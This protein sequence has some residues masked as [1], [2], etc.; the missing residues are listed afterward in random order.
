M[1][2][3][4][5]YFWGN[6]RVFVTGATGLVGP[7]LIKLL[8]DKGA[9]VVALINNY[10][11]PSELFLSGNIHRVTVIEGSIDEYSVIENVLKKQDIE[12][13]FHLAST[14]NNYGKAF[15]PLRTFDTNI[16]GTYNLLEACRLFGDKSMC[17]VTTS[18][19]EV[20]RDQN[21]S[22]FSD[23]ITQIEHPYEASKKSADMIC[24]VYRT[25]YGLNVSTII[26]P[27]LYGGGDFN[28][29]RIVPGTI[30]S[31]I[32]N[33]RPIIRSNG[34]LVRSYLYVLDFVQALLMIAENS[35]SKAKG[36]MI[37]NFKEIELLSTIEIVKRII[38]RSKHYELKPVIQNTSKDEKRYLTQSYSN[39]VDEIGWSQN[40]TLDEGL[41]DTIEWY[42]NYFNL[43]PA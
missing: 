43:N 40:Y 18:S 11:L 31:I 38:K 2:N 17:S 23:K 29:D 25:T 7:W 3:L 32:Q 28:W 37:Y 22:P 35:I 9:Q 30:R 39:L 41:Y 4:N 8:L 34:A 24:Q 14:N 33:E 19:R 10:N 13:V 16:R 1:N 26:S 12:V 5:N 20:Y 15:S 6:K 21:Q 36:S 27:N 42:V